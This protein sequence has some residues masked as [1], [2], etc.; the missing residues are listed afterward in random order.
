M[1]SGN[2]LAL[3]MGLALLYGSQGQAEPLYMRFWRKP[4]ASTAARSHRS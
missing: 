4:M 1:K 2:R 3:T